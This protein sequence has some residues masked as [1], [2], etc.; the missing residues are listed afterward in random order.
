MRLSQ[1]HLSTLVIHQAKNRV[2]ARDFAVVAQFDSGLKRA[3]ARLVSPTISWNSSS[4]ITA[5][6]L[7][8][9]ATF[10]R[11]FEQPVH[12]LVDV[13]AARCGGELKRRTNVLVECDLWPQGQ[14]LKEFARAVHCAFDRPRQAGVEC[15]GKL[16]GEALFGGGAQEVDIRNQE[17]L[18]A[19]LVDDGGSE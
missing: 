8:R 19:D 13:G 17:M 9:L 11:Y 14:T 2:D 3:P 1:F 16:A 18:L 12:G 4:T 5:W 7:R 10:L 6:R 15:C